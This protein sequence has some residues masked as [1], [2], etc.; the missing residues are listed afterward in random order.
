VLRFTTREITKHNVFA[1]D[2]HFVF[3]FLFF[4]S[5]ST[6][7]GEQPLGHRL[8]DDHDALTT[9]FKLLHSIAP[10]RRISSLS[11]D[12]MESIYVRFLLPL[13]LCFGH[14]ALASFLHSIDYQRPWTNFGYPS[15][16]LFFPLLLP[17]FHVVPVFL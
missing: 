1:F 13:A 14:L 7:K 17:R 12:L 15:A 5:P 11:E 9:A 3:F 6:I 16:T 8:A 2:A 4:S 10:F